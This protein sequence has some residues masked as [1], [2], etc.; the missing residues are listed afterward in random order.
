MGRLSMAQYLF[1]SS[2]ANM[3]LQLTCCSNSMADSK[4]VVEAGAV[5]V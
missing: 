3:L 2:T 5:S 4:Q 1:L